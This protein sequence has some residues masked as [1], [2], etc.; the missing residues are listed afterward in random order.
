MKKSEAYNT[1]SIDRFFRGAFS[2]DILLITYHDK[3]L[4]ILL[5]E[6][7]EIPFQNEWGLPGELILPN[8]DVDEAMEKLMTT[9]V[10]QSD[11]YKKQLTTFSNINR[12]P[13]GRIVTFAYYGLIPF[14]RLNQNLSSELKWCEISK[15]PKLILD[16]NHIVDKVFQRFR[17]GLLS[18]PIVFHTLPDKF[19][20]SDIIGV[21]EQALNETFD[22]RNFRKKILSSRIIIPLGEFRKSKSHGGRPAELYE[23]NTTK[24]KI[25]K[26]RIRFDLFN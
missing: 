6:K 24:K 17:K 2:V 10:G 16:H 15:L 9:L 5:Q 12:H 11:F 18:R 22:V 21:Y 23:L 19:I 13:L 3:K 7:K 25:T 20:L 1:I 26:D 14:E 4:K 8:E